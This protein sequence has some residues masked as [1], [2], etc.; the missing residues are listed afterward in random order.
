MNKIVTFSILFG[1][2]VID[3]EC[4]SVGQTSTPQSQ[5]TKYFRN[6]APFST[7]NKIEDDILT[8]SENEDD[9]ADTAVSNDDIFTS[10]VNILEDKNFVSKREANIVDISSNKHSLHNQESIQTFSL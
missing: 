2:L 10:T 9:N 6:F 3:C 4:R 1:Q 8:L 7:Y 5:R